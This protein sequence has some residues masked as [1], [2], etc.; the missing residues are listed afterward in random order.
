METDSF[1]LSVNTKDIII[2]I[3]ILEEFFD[4]TFLNEIMNYTVKKTVTYMEKL[5]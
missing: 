2:D 5:R 3:K 1:A 4:F